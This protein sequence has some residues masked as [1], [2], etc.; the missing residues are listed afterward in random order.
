VTGVLDRLP[1]WTTTGVGSLPGVDAAAAARH[2]VDAYSLPFCP[3]LPALEGDMVAEWLVGGRVNAHRPRAWEPWRAALAGAAP[4]HRVVKLQVA[5]PMTLA[6]ALARTAGTMP[7]EPEL[8]QRAGE[9]AA[10]QAVTVAGWVQELR[11]DG[12]DALLVL[13]EP[14]LA[15]T[16]WEGLDTVWAPLRATAPAWGLH[17]C[18]AVPWPV[19]A[20]TA[21]DLL[22]F[23][24]TLGFDDVGA[25]A[26]DDADIHVAWGVLAPHRPQEDTMANRR[27]DDA[28][29]R[30]S[31]V[32]ARKSLLTATCGSGLLS[33]ER[34]AEVTARLAAL[35]AV[36][37]EV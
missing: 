9:V 12:L 8:L 18:G 5:G 26:L 1:A 2:A 30:L 36:R 10:A 24:L 4:A 16:P 25:A 27:L 35:G 19:V 6:V 22:S 13:D 20:A 3:Q 32:P 21:P 7:G 14:L 34:E 23:D 31:V 33:P 11:A 29:A 28:L 17:L 37:A 15:Q